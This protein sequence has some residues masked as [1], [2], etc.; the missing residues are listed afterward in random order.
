MGAVLRRIFHA[1]HD[2]NGPVVAEGFCCPTD[3]Q[4]RGVVVLKGLR[5]IR[6]CL[7]C[8]EIFSHSTDLL[9]PN[10]VPSRDVLDT[11]GRQEGSPVT[12][13]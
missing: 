8:G 1:I 3:K 13:E 10:A 11:F 9:E 7:Y 6:R 4:N 12:V 2:H 5:A